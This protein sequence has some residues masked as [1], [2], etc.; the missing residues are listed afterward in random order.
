MH[1]FN[2][3]HRKAA[4]EVFPT[5]LAA[6]TPVVAFTATRW[7]TLLKPQPEWSAAPPAAADCYRFC[8]AQPAVQLVLTAPKSLAEL[9][10]NLQ[11]LALPPMNADARDHWE[12]FGDIV[13]KAQGGQ[14][15]TYESRWP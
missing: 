12:R 5:A 4:T 8:L 15:D 6:Q 2:M 10:E 3:A 14:T 1:R 11:V 13:Y 9:D 7:G